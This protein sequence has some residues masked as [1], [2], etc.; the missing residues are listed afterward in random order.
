MGGA[1]AALMMTLTITGIPGHRAVAQS[2]FEPTRSDQARLEQSESVQ[3]E[4]RSPDSTLA[5]VSACTVQ[6]QSSITPII[7]RPT[8][9]SAQWGVVVEPLDGPMPLYSYNDDSYFI[10]ASNIKLLTTAAALQSLRF[11]NESDL[12]AFH[13]WIQVTNRDSNNGYADALLRRLGGTQTVNQALA[14]LGIDPYSYRQVDGSGLSRYNMAKPK[15]FISVLKAMTVAPG[16]NIFYGSLP[17]AGYSGTL[18][19]RF[20]GTPAQGLVRAKTGTLRGVRALSGY[21]DHPSHGTLVFSI[22]VN[23]PNQSGTVML[24]AIDEIVLETL[25]LEQC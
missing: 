6:L 18:R 22:M 8:F 14:S 17:V 23:Q 3:G 25:E 2:R 16:N 12:F 5:G 20:R 4:G 7:E 19:N 15:T 21:L 1:I 10:P 24:Q 11:T 9:Q 13:R